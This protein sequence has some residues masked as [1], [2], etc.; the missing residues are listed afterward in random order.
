[1]CIGFLGVPLRT[2]VREE[3]GKQHEGR[4]RKLKCD[5]IAGVAS[6]DPLG[7]SDTELRLLHSRQR[8][9]DLCNATLPSP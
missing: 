5:I 2:T 9:A 7:S 1:M 8:G 4:M 3:K 6:A